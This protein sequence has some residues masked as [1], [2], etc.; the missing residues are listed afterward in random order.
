M[1]KTKS[2]VVVKFLSK[3]GLGVEEGDSFVS[4][5]LDLSTPASIFVPMERNYLVHQ[6]HR[7]GGCC[8]KVM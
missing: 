5:Q 2:N 4:F 1:R 3:K 6:Q 7:H 8:I